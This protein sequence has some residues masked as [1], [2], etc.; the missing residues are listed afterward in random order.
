[1]GNRMALEILDIT[2]D[3]C[4]GARNGSRDTYDNS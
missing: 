2:Y 1:M 4:N 3:I